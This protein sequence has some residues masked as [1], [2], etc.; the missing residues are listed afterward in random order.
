MIRIEAEDQR[1]ACAL[2]AHFGRGNVDG[3]DAIIH[4]TN[5]TGRLTELLIAVLHFYAEVV[6]ELRTPAGLDLLT[7]HV[8]RLAALEDDQ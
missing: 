1:R 3:I 8:L 6:P 5:Q 2:I 4:E 7:R